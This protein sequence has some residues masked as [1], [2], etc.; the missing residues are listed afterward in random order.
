[1]PH[2]PRLGSTVPAFLDRSDT[3]SV[4]YW[5]VSPPAEV[6]PWVEAIALVEAAGD[7]P[8]RTWRLVPDARCRVRLPGL[9]G[10]RPELF[11]PAFGPR[12]LRA[13]APGP[14]VIVRFV[15]WASGVLGVKQPRT[16]RG[17][18]WWRSAAADWEPSGPGGAASWY[19]HTCDWLLRVLPLRGPDLRVRDAWGGVAA[20]DC[21][22]EVAERVGCSPRNLLRSFRQAV[23]CPPSW[24]LDLERLRRA[25]RLLRSNLE[26]SW[27]QAALAA[28]Y[29]DQSHFNRAFA[30]LV[31]L[32]PGRFFGEGHHHVNDVFARQVT[33]Q[34]EG[35]EVRAV[36]QPVMREPRP[37]KLP[38]RH[39]RMA[40]RS[41]GR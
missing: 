20:G 5:E 19:R 37:L 40:V 32:A 36:G 1:M 29:G 14:A 17:G 24:A 23:G 26:M 2:N 31:A 15:P 33:A 28:G 30:R 16:G 34:T 8:R 7:I 27:V 25:L 3:P 18:E 35:L 13:V 39:R 11:P 4:R 12:L 41:G 10:S 22:S 21:V 6:A 38:A 9:R